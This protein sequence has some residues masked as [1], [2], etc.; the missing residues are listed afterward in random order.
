MRMSSVRLGRLIYIGND[1]INSMFVT[2]F[3]DGSKLCSDV[4]QVGSFS[5]W[6]KQLIR[7]IHTRLGIFS[8]S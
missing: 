2:S 8:I 6:L 7:S 3:Y 1:E 4:N 5:N